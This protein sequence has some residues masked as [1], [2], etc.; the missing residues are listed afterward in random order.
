MKKILII[1]MLGVLQG[2]VGLA[3]GT[4]GTFESERSLVNISNEKNTFNYPG[5]TELL[6][7]DQLLS[8]WGAPESIVKEGRCEIIT[9]HNGYSWSGVGAFVFVV[10][11]PILLPTGKEK[12]KF[13]FIDGEFV[14]LVSEY[15]EVA[16]AFGFM[17]GSNE[18]GAQAGPV[19][20]ERTR[21]VDVTWCDLP[22]QM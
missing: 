14:R 17:C 6:T 3:V 1:V 20:N 7:K 15:G 11:I 4:Y 21:N 13:Y 2:C 5:S 12:N 16:A 9:Y 22:S 18:C 19:N 10:P 8:A